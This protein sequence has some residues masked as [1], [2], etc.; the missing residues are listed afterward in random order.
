MSGW[1][2]TFEI[3]M[4]GGKHDLMENESRTTRSVT[5]RL[6]SFP[7]LV[8]LPKLKLFSKIPGQ[9]RGPKLL[10]LTYSGVMAKN[11]N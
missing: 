1:E 7:W 6:L 8:S 3:T 2:Y 10:R 11:P 9:E 4:N 5:A